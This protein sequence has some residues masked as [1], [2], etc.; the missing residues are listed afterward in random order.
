[1]ML[2]RAT[3]YWAVAAVLSVFLFWV[4]LRLTPAAPWAIAFSLS[5]LMFVGLFASAAYRGR[6]QGEGARK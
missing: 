5:M 6:S 1:M 2:T 3:S 4:L